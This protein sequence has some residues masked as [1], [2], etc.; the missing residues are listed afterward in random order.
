MRRALLAAS[1]ALLRAVLWTYPRD[2]REELGAEMRR[3]FRDQCEAA[4]DRG[5]GPA[6]VGLWARTAW[7]GLANGLGERGR[8]AGSRALDGN[9]REGWMR[10]W[11]GIG[12]DV[13]HALRALG[14]DRAYTLVAV[15]MLAVAVGGTTGVY[16]LA[17]TL[18]LDPIPGLEDPDAV[19]MLGLQRSSGGGFGTFP[20]PVVAA[21]R[22]SVASFE[23]VVGAQRITLDLRTEG[24][25]TRVT[26]EIVDGAFFDVLGVRPAP[27]RGF[28][29]EETGAPGGPLVT[30]ISHAAWTARFGADPSVVGSTVSLNGR[31][32]TVVGVAP[33]GFVGIYIGG[34]PPEFWVPMSAQPA[35]MPTEG[36]DPLTSMGDF[37]VRP[38][39]RLTDG[40]TM[41]VA[42][43]E[44]EVLMQSFRERF[45]G[46][47]DL[48]ISLTDRLATPRPDQRAEL[49]RLLTL[50]LGVVGVVLLVVCTNLANLGLSRVAAR[51][52]EIGVRLALGSGRARVARRMFVES[53]LL[54]SA[55]AGIG[56]L[57]AGP[58][59]E[60]L[61]GLYG[62]GLA[63]PVEVDA[64]VAAGAV[65][66]AVLTGV[67]VGVGPALMAVRSNAL[68]RLSSGRAGAQDR[69]SRLRRALSVA[70]VAL[71]TVLL[72]GSV[73]LLRSVRNV[74]SVDPGF[75]AAGALSVGFDLT[76]RD[77]GEG[78][79]WSLATRMTERLGALPGVEAVA[80]ALNPP[81]GGS[82]RGGGFYVE[83]ASPPPGEERFSAPYNVVGPGYFA[84]MGIPVV[85]GREFDATDDADSRPVA[86]VS[87]SFARRHWPGQDALGKRIA[88][89]GPD[90]PWIE[91]VGVVGDIRWTSL[92]EDPAAFFYRPFLQREEARGTLV[93][94]AGASAA[95]LIPTIREEVR[96]LD[97]GLPALRIR[98]LDAMVDDTTA[99]H[100]MMAGVTGAFTAL[101]LFLVAVGLYGLLSYAVSGR[102]REI[103][104]R[105]SLGAK[106]GAVTRLV[107]RDAMV[108]TGLG[109]LLGLAGA[110]A[111]SRLLDAVLF[112]V[113]PFD[114]GAYALAALALVLVTGLATWL[115][116][117]RA[118]RVN[119]VEALRAE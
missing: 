30:V 57:L 56:V 108:L 17:R 29:E 58:F 7:K 116:A 46:A 96:S 111:T 22:E 69:S 100:R 43:D 78:A 67:I 63:V 73:L 109:L 66:L 20:Y 112:G 52:R 15:L 85:R 93:V 90:G 34:S 74:T 2:Y 86:I 97:P 118:S 39:G 101:A 1:D 98:L 64:S 44:L 13:K 8:P 47:A 89:E 79:M 3:T 76:G 83:G 92:E 32:F 19:V 87:E 21:I 102:T 11:D 105:M 37:W 35:A 114:P 10:T 23:G 18:L 51:S 119:P 14:K 48:S 26:G 84:A 50:I 75:A 59:A 71:S 62:G 12:L 88:R 24:P 61:Y 103:G 95:S 33:E 65:G 82:R 25:P 41:E 70:Q 27:G 80:F 6:I 31:A 99:R 106:A 5:G 107:T 45:P 81:F 91:V 28:S 68:A 94:R 115:P 54:S 104:V 53:F 4:L 113:S 9:A 49:I 40:R 72:V 36:W 42:A 60:L 110:L 55:G 16:A 77:R 38:V 117:H